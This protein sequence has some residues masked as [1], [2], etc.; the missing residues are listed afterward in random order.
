MNYYDRPLATRTKEE[1]S[2]RHN[3]IILGPSQSAASQHH[4]VSIDKPVK[5]SPIYQCDITGNFKYSKFFL[6]I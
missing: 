4:L 1:G 5:S 6:E 2:F 3:I